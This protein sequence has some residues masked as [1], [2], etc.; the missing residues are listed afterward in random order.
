[1]NNDYDYIFKVIIIGDHSCGKTSLVS[2]FADASRPME[3]QATIGVDFTAKYYTNSKGKRIKLYLWDTAG[4]E[5]FRSVVQL[6]Y[7]NLAGA[8]FVFD[9]TNPKT[10]RNL[11][12]WLGELQERNDNEIPVPMLLLANKI[13][14]AEQRIVGRNEADTYAREHGMLYEEVS[15]LNNTNTNAALSRLFEKIYDEFIDNDARCTGIKA[16]LIP[17]KQKSFWSRSCFFF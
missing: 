7:K 17:V 14:K 8:V 2:R 1:M 3:E 4:Q 15:V 6:Y 13:D 9:V 5:A 12:Y 11:D 16:K 10:F